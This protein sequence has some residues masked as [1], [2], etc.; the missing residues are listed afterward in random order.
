L[1]FVANG[2]CLRRCAAA[3]GGFIVVVSPQD[4]DDDDDEEVA[5]TGDAAI[6]TRFT[7]RKLSLSC[8]FWDQN[9]QKRV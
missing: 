7:Q 8:L 6:P 9:R 2:R 4:D 1:F 3:A 5:S